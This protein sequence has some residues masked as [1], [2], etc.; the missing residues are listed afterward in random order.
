RSA[1]Q[2][3]RLPHH[4]NVSTLVADVTDEALLAA[5]MDG[6]FA[7]LSAAPYHV[8]RHVAHAARA[9]GIHYLDLTEDVATTRL[10]KE[11]AK[12]AQSAFIPQ[13]GLA[14]GFISIVAS[15][16]ARRFD[17]LDSVRMRVGALP[18]FPSNALSYNLTWSTEGVINE[19]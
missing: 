13:C 2:L 3:A 18:I 19:Y 5:R 10:A 16:L 17:T 4:P 8:T 14:P 6:C 11:L 7:V 9:A 15:D 1:D 12:D